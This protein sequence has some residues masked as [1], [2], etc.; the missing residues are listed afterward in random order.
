MSKTKE[1]R[2]GFFGFYD[3]VVNRFVGVFEKRIDFSKYEQ[4]LEEFNEALTAFKD[5]LK[6]RKSI[7]VMRYSDDPFGYL[8]DVFKIADYYLARNR[9]YIE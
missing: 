6:K 1:P 2:S 7:P 4:Y 8:S 9:F 5:D 3:S